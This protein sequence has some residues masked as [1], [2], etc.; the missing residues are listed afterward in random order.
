MP[1]SPFTNC[2][3]TPVVGHQG[4]Y[5]AAK[6]N[7]CEQEGTYPADLIAKVEQANCKATEHDTKGFN[8]MVFSSSQLEPWTA[9]CESWGGGELT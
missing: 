1:L 4:I 5:H 2:L 9:P 3:G 6:C 7:K 8:G